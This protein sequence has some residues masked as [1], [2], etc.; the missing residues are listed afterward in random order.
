MSTS[1]GETTTQ[2]VKDPAAT[3]SAEDAV[4]RVL[5]SCINKSKMENSHVSTGLFKHEGLL[6]TLPG[7]LMGMN[8]GF[9]S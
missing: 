5:E 3:K 8:L 2:D 1:D 9:S 6:T 4:T 7:E